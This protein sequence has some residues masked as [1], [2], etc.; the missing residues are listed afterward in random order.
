MPGRKVP[1]Y[2]SVPMSQT[3]QPTPGEMRA[4]ANQLLAWADQLAAP[5]A[6]AVAGPCDAIGP[7]TILAF[8]TRARDIR[9]RRT[10]TF[11]HL[12]LR[13]PMWDVMLGLFIEQES[14][15][16]VSVDR[17]VLVSDADEAVLRHAVAVLVTNGL[18]QRIADP[19]DDRVVWLT[20]SPAGLAGMR[21]HL[22]EAST[23]MPVQAGVETRA[24]LEAA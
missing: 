2:G 16:R 21:D 1:P 5:P 18:V 22:T 14:G 12:R 17:L 11:P 6:R 3:V 19:F 23:A 4:L 20:L 9:R 13:E 7:E 8:A 15:R 24:M 10:V